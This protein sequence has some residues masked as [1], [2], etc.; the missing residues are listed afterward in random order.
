MSTSPSMI[1]AGQLFCASRIWVGF[2]WCYSDWVCRILVKE[3]NKG[4]A[5]LI[6]TTSPGQMYAL[7]GY[8]AVYGLAL[9]ILGICLL[10]LVFTAESVKFGDNGQWFFVMYFTASRWI[11]FFI[12]WFILFSFPFPSLN[13]DFLFIYFADYFCFLYITILTLIYTIIYRIFLFLLIFP[14]TILL[15]V[16]VY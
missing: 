6:I 10:L 1:L 3:R 15:I 16:I 5:V 7:G 14:S 9:G 13:V 12:P 4:T 2:T 11:I 8:V